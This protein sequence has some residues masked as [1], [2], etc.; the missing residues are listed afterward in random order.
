[1]AGV[2]PLV[3]IAAAPWRGQQ[4]DL[5]PVESFDG[6]FDRPPRVSWGRALPGGRPSAGARSELGR[7]HLT[8]SSI[9]V[10][11]S[12]DDALFEL[13]RDDGSLVR[14]FPAGAAVMA[15]PEVRDAFVLF[16]DSA[17]YTWRY[18]REGSLAWKHYAGAPVLARPL[19]VADAAYIS[20]LD[21]TVHAVDLASGATRWLYTHPRDATRQADLELFGA[22]TPVLAAGLLL[23]GFHDGSLVALDEASGEPAWESRVGEGRYPDLIGPPLIEGQHAFLGGFSAPFLCLDLDSRVVAWR[24]DAGVAAQAAVQG[25]TVFV[26]GSDGKLRALDRYSGVE[27]WSWDSQTAG[28]LTAPLSTQAGLLI[29]SSDGGIWLIDPYTGLETWHFDEGYMLDGVS[30]ALAIDGRQAIA[31]TNA[32][33]LLSLVVPRA[34]TP[35]PH[36]ADPLWQAPFASDA[37]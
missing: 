31:V 16:S 21:G 23:V 6:A 35:G 10:G 17:G 18:D 13:R 27:I 19:V 2:L 26:P 8:A 12:G 28:A 32:G 24:L 3:L 37:R 36:A 15:E 5:V 4:V 1:M 11:S 25:Q 9:F 30:V 33:N 29:A 22:P 34:S 20:A 14:S 7:P